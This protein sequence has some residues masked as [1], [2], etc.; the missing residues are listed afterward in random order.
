M[1]ETILL[2]GQPAFTGT[3]PMARHD[4]IVDLTQTRVIHTW[5]S[6]AV[7]IARRLYSWLGVPQDLPF[8]EVV[9]DQL[10]ER[11]QCQRHFY[12][13]KGVIHVLSPDLR[14]DA[15]TLVE[16]VEVLA[17]AYKGI[18]AAFVWQER[19]TL[20]LPPLATG[21]LA[22]P[23]APYLPMLTGAALEQALDDLD[24]WH[25]AGFTKRRVYLCIQDRADLPLFRE[26][27][28]AGAPPGAT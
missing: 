16:A 17:R 11:G 13:D 8:P 20:R 2:Y 9:T 1:G 26:Q 22:G 14:E 21:E 4:I 27:I 19:G 6:N 3:L 15:T 24:H 5:P 18:L 23:F 7:G 10:T 25:Q 12:G 28:Q